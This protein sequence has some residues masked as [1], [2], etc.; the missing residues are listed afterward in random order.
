MLSQAR[1][2][3]RR[4][5]L[6]GLVAALGL[7][8]GC[9]GVGRDRAPVPRNDVEFIDDMIPHHEGAVVMVDEVLARGDSNDVRRIAEKIKENE[10]A[11]IEHMRSLRA[12]LGESEEPKRKAQ[13]P[14]MKADMSDLHSL[15]GEPLDD[16]FLR[17]MIAHHAQG[18]T[19]IHRARPNLQSEKT[20][21][22]ADTSFVQKTR[23][24]YE[25]VELLAE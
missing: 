23:E 6:L 11:E 22:T 8:I 20:R 5:R 13:D 12:E 18:V 9:E 4:A 14:Q 10:L 21:E 15:Y 16:Q 24:M 17:D 2:A 1:S 7:A 19:M 25:L 3:P